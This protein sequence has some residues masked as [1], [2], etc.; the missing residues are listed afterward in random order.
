MK[1][2][3]KL[4]KVEIRGFKSFSSK[5]VL[6]LLLGDINVLLGANGSG[7]SNFISF[8]R[9]LNFMMTGSFQTYIETVGTAESFLHYGSK[10]TKSISGMLSFSDN[11]SK[12]IYR[13]TLSHATP[14]RLIIT[15]EEI[16]WEKKGNQKPFRQL[17]ETTYKESALRLST[18]ETA[19]VI[20]KILT[21]CKVF[22]FHDTTAEGYLRKS[23]HVDNA[24]FLQSEGGNLA[25]F[26]YT[27]KQENE[28]Y[29]NR[30]VSYISEVMPQFKDFYL[31][32][33]AAGYVLLRW[34][35]NASDD[36][37]LLP[38]QISDGSLRF[39]A[40]ATL[41]LQP[42]AKMPSIIILDEPEL[43]LHPMAIIQLA[44]MVKQASE[45]AQIILATQSPQL[46]DA[47]N[48]SEIRIVER[49]GSNTTVRSL[50]E[51]ALKEWL[52]VYSISELWNKNVLGGRP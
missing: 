23:S 31:E 7:K 44:E 39:M 29:Y 1:K 52:D 20:R 28:V 18:N 4:E 21:N 24:S 32:P 43:G 49:E 22:Q 3:F 9:M 19:K 34:V 11:S 51:K 2:C 36:Y 45:Y 47:F 41:L 33:N 48:P 5:E 14:D 8:F 37:I 38:S 6:S 26:L 30:I 35:D 17:L 46:A 13:F 27:M 10:I 50:D 42:P 15:S 40:L 25:A 12:D 16:E